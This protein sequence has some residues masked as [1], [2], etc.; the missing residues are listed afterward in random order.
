MVRYE[1]VSQEYQRLSAEQGGD[2]DTLL[3]LETEN[4]SMKMALV[5]RHSPDLLD[6]IDD[7][8]KALSLRV[9]PLTTS[10]DRDPFVVVLIDGDGMIFRDEFIRDGENGGRRAAVQLHAAIADYIE[11]ENPIIPIQSRIFCYIW[12]NVKGLAEVLVRTGVIEQTRQF[13][14]FVQGFTSDKGLFSFA[15]VGPG[16]DRA[17]KKVIGTSHPGMHQYLIPANHYRTFQSICQQSPLSADFLRML[18]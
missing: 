18:S 17:D 7:S 12:A 14:D 3:A 4:R 5:R 11:R 10:Q 6:P 15:N 13:E 2:R 8:R 1:Y 16:K 9:P